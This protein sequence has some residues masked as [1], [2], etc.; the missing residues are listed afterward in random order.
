MVASIGGYLAGSVAPLATCFR[1]IAEWI[2]RRAFRARIPGILAGFCAGRVGKRDQS[3]TGDIELVANQI[4]PRPFHPLG[5]GIGLP[6]LLNA[7]VLNEFDRRKPLRESPAG[8]MGPA[9]A[10][11]LAAT[12]SKP[13]ANNVR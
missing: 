6:F 7:L 3:W 1:N 4:L 9:A 5:N 2:A 10:L 12:R 11:P 8:E 13:A